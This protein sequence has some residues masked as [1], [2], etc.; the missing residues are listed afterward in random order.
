MNHAFNITF[1]KYYMRLVKHVCFQYMLTPL[2]LIIKNLLLA[3]AQDII[4]IF[5]ICACTRRQ[6]FVMIL[7]TWSI[8]PSWRWR[9]ANIGN[10]SYYT[11]FPPTKIDPIPQYRYTDGSRSVRQLRGLFG[12][13]GYGIYT[14]VVCFVY[15]LIHAPIRDF[16]RLEL[17]R[18]VVEC[19]MFFTVV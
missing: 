5:L 15:Y 4:N 18:V 19:G 10:V 17:V 16:W 14:F 1:W 11:Y 12:Y 3:I 9:S 6:P 13:F 7:C 8:P 2:V